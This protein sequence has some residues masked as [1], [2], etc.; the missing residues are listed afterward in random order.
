MKPGTAISYFATPIAGFVG[1]D[2][3]DPMTHDL[4]PDSNCAKMR[5]DFDNAEHIKDYTNAIL[6][7]IRKRGKYEP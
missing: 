6:D 1:V 7:R 3:Y 4:R 5:D 2:C